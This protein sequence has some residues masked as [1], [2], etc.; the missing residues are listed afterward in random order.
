[1]YGFSHGGGD[2]PRRSAPTI[3]SRVNPRSN[4]PVL[5]RQG[6]PVKSQRSNKATPMLLALAMLASVLTILAPTEPVAA[7]ALPENLMV[8]ATITAGSFA[9][10]LTAADTGILND[11]S[12]DN[13]Y[14][15]STSGERTA[16]HSN[17]IFIDLGSIQPVS[18]LN[19]FHDPMNTETGGAR[20]DY[21][22]TPIGDGDDRLVVLDAQLNSRSTV[23][24]DSAAATEGIRYIRIQTIINEHQLSFAEIEAYGPLVTAE[25]NG[26]VDTS[27]SLTDGA[28]ATAW[29]GQTGIRTGLDPM[30]LFDSNTSTAART[31]SKDAGV[32]VDG[33]F[34]QIDLRTTIDVGTIEIDNLALAD[35]S[36]GIRILT[37]DD[38]GLSGTDLASTDA[39][40]PGRSGAYVAT[41][42]GVVS[43][44][45]SIDVN[46]PVRF[47]RIQR[48]SCGTVQA[49]EVRVFPSE[50]AVLVEHIDTQYADVGQVV[51]I[52]LT[53][54]GDAPLELNAKGFPGSMTF[55]QAAGA[56][57][58]APVQSGRWYIEATV[59]AEDGRTSTLRFEFVVVDGAP[60]GE[61]V[62][63]PA[64]DIESLSERPTATVN[65]VI[66]ANYERWALSGGNPNDTTPSLDITVWDLV[67]IGD[68]MYVGGEFNQVSGDGGGDQ[69]Y[70]ARFDINS[71]AWDST[72]RP[73]LD[74]NVHAL[75]IS[76][77]GRLLIGGEF[78]NVDGVPGTAGLAAIDVRTGQV[79][80]TFEAWVE[81]PWNPT[82]PAVVRDIE[83]VGDY[84]YIVGKFSHINGAGGGRERAYSAA[85]VTASYGTIDSSWKPVVT[86]SSGWGINANHEA[87]RVYM[88]GFMSAINGEFGTAGGAGVDASTGAS[89]DNNFL[90]D[91]IK[92]ANQK[93]DVTTYDDVFWTAG[94]EHYVAMNVIDEAPPG[95]S[96]D[97][98]STTGMY[99]D[100]GLGC[101]S[102]G[103]D[104]Q[105][106]EKIGNFIIS[107]C[108]CQAA[109][110]ES[111]HAWSPN[112]G[113]GGA[114]YDNVTG[115]RTEHRVAMAY[116]AYG[117]QVGQVVDWIPDIEGGIDGSWAATT[118]TNGC[119]WIGGDITGGGNATGGA[120]F[121]EG[122]IRYCAP[123][124]DTVSILRVVE[125]TTEQITLRW[126]P[127]NEGDSSG[128]FVIERDGSYAGFVP[129]TGNVE[130]FFTDT[131]VEPLQ[132][133]T[134]NVIPQTVL[135]VRGI[136]RTIN[137][138][139]GA[140]SEDPSV[141]T[142]L[143]VA[144]DGGQVTVTW[145][146]STDDSGVTGYLVYRNDAYIGYSDTTSFSEAFV[147]DAVY[148]VRAVDVADRRS[149][150]SQPISVDEAIPD[151]TPPSVPA[152]LTVA[153]NA[154]AAQL[155]WTA[156][157]DD[158]VVTGYLIFRNGAYLGWTATPGYL[159]TEPT[160][161]DTYTVRAQDGTNRSEHSAS[162]TYVDPAG[163]DAES[164][165][166]PTGLQA[167]LAGSDVTLTWNASGDNMGVTGYLV[168][169]NGAY[170]GWS[171]TTSFT[172]T[173]VTPGSYSYDLRAVD[174]AQ[175]RSEKSEAVSVQ[176]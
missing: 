72:F 29:P 138:T 172:D 22:T 125:E 73:V 8:G 154:G 157:T 159:D 67:Q 124:S 43:G 79:D 120:V 25:P 97:V 102:A 39:E 100:D 103:G 107:G 3:R 5:V 112:E 85:R 163:P 128:G 64:V 13:R 12:T 70:L 17:N 122:F 56:I 127:D 164:P 92:S 93:F 81:R 69:A 147:P 144:L 111:G 134:Y 82:A 15:F 108:H 167:S 168:Y 174:A 143:G 94:A 149:D 14:V 48:T 161:G 46:R 116:Y 101:C 155:N 90:P 95:R 119:L 151:T 55:D 98:F 84:L 132:S 35:C 156:S 146:P 126:T 89:V 51:N 2:L 60:V 63:S 32:T 54:Q 61:Q 148:T 176:L 45:I 80:T 42:L 52:P 140:D 121:A 78:T 96:T 158:R 36:G 123:P 58:G 37:T 21:S 110:L 68:H 135:E 74:G 114:H 104:Y 131:T 109:T 11:G 118:D 30:F 40:S 26:P 50:T 130:H 153:D 139:A 34:L 115:E 53:T 160:D 117:P 10:G 38:G 7:D 77:R 28:I 71:G 19:L 4:T 18:M 105:F 113:Y 47:I 129:N 170:I 31:G 173:G 136:G 99:G 91:I 27:V 9:S 88:A 62:E 142:G 1:M 133:Y 33:A 23:I 66:G 6:T 59:L 169:R 165:T 41:D 150:K 49:S 162:A 145:A 75:E 24:L 152:D 20:I 76:P 141:P 166:I 16:P 83:V 137:A 57:V 65:G 86:G 171:P 175:N 44:N 106:I 87:D